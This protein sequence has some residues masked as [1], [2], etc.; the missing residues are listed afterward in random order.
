MMK[1]FLFSFG[2]IGLVVFGVWTLPDAQAQG[3]VNDLLGRINQL[4]A[5]QGLPAYRLNNTLRAAAQNQA[6]WMATS[7]QVSHTQSNGSS[8]RD[9]ATAAGYGSSWVS[10]NIYMGTLATVDSAWQF[11]LNSPIHY[12][13][14]I[15]PNYQDIG[16]ASASGAGGKSFVL[17]FGNPGSSSASVPRG[18][19]RSN[20]A[21][22]ESSG[23]PPPPPYFKGVDEQGYILHEIQ[24][25][26][27][28]GDIALIYG[29]TWDDIPQILDSNDLSPDDQRNLAVGEILRVPPQAG[30]YT[31]TPS[32]S[33][34]AETTP[35]TTEPAA[36]ETAAETATVNTDEILP[37]PTPGSDSPAM[38][39]TATPQNGLVQPETYTRPARTPSPA[40]T[41]TRLPV[42]QAAMRVATLP[43]AA[44]ATD[45]TDS[46]AQT[47]ASPPTT[48]ERPNRTQTPPLWLILAVGIQVLVLAVASVEYVRRH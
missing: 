44:D 31:P 2:L 11:W 25:G 46:S 10:E 47:A 48:I 33:A 18:N 6:T 34:D 1:R 7:G 14:L 9:R 39:A 43:S 42:T 32:N 36:P 35:Q 27:T 15:S 37:T 3:V 29:Y 22:S 4:R 19:T 38:P 30:T 26:D 13:G 17:V 28:L 24:P 40:V 45:S 12:R 5:E 21:A 20:N 16:I 41:P 23:P 8:V